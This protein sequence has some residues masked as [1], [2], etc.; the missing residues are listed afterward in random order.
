ME[1]TRTTNAEA[2]R[3]ALVTARALLGQNGNRLRLVLAICICCAAS[4]LPTLLI[5]WPFSVLLDWETLLNENGALVVL[6]Y[7]VEAP[8]RAAFFFFL[9]IP[10]YL[11][12]FRMAVRMSRQEMTE[13]YDVFYY[14]AGKALYLRGIKI[15]SR[16][17][18]SL[19]P[20]YLFCSVYQMFYR[21]QLVWTGV[22]VLLLLLLYLVIASFSGGFVLLS[23]LKETTPVGECMRMAKLIS[24]GRRW[25]NLLLSLSFFWR[26]ALSLIPAGVLLLIHTLPLCLL[27][28]ANYT[29]RRI[30]ATDNC[31]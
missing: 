2:R 26:L 31:E 24:R 4:L 15:I 10:L 30:E 27:A 1:F 29:L 9:V 8:L 20:L 23:T 16:A 12:G 18:W 7:M 6:L 22:I 21:P 19:L 17:F 25:S 3:G 28:S 14:F 11:G 5:S 13:I